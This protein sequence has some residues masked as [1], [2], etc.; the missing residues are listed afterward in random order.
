LGLTPP[1]R[2]ASFL[3]FQPHHLFPLTP[4]SNHPNSLPIWLTLSPESCCTILPFTHPSNFTWGPDTSFHDE[5]RL[6][7]TEVE[8]LGPVSTWDLQSQLSPQPDSKVRL[9]FPSPLGILGLTDLHP[10]HDS[11]PF[12]PLGFLETPDFVQ[13]MHAFWCALLPWSH[14]QTHPK[15]ILTTLCAESEGKERPSSTSQTTLA[16][17]CLAHVF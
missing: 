3:S 12:C 13:T 1:P 6:E 16:I 11:C 4:F 10:S 15:L 7:R 14:L 8:D 17:L 2:A 9:L 5:L